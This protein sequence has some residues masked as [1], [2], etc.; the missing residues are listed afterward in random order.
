ML[1]INHKNDIII[2]FKKIGEPGWIEK[3]KLIIQSYAD[4]WGEKTPKTKTQQSIDQLEQKLGT[5]LPD[6]LKLFYTEF[7]VAD[8]GEQLLDFSKIGWLKNIWAK[9]PEQGP[10]FSKEELSILPHLVVFSD[11]LGNGNMFCF[12][13][14]NKA[15]YYFDHDQKPLLQKLFNSVDDYIK[16]CLIFS[17]AA[18][19][20]ENLQE[21]VDSWV[22]A[23]A[24]DCFG[25]STVK[26]W[27]Y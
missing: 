26:K 22:E 7:G 10:N 12:H 24:I 25:K 21:K 8:I 16:G 15:V 2:P 5:Q 1:E 23:V 27:R 18:L 20:N 19:C 14:K 4:V 13:S 11:Y 6:S 17:Q 9:N 3:T